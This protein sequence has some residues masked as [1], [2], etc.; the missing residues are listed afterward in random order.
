MSIQQ[1]TVVQK[2]ITEPTKISDKKNHHPVMLT[3][4][5]IKVSAMRTIKAEQSK[6][7]L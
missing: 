6:Y 2:I 5:K 7:C 4:I 3:Q 1:C